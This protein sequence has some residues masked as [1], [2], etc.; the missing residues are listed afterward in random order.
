MIPKTLIDVEQLATKIIAYAEKEEEEEGGG[1]E[2]EEE[3][4]AAAAQ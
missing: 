3:A 2:A 4:A 1:G